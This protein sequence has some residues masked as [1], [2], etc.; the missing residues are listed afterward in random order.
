MTRFI[1][2]CA[3]TIA[4]L[5][6]ANVFTLDVQAGDSGLT[7]RPTNLT[8]VAPER[9][10]NRFGVT[11]ENAHDYTFGATFLKTHPNDN[12]VMYL[13]WYAGQI[14]R[15]EY[16]GSQLINRSLFLDI[17]DRT[18][19]F[20]DGT[21]YAGMGI[22][23]MEFDP[24]FANNNQVYIY[25]GSAPNSMAPPLEQR[26]S[27]FTLAPDGLTIDESSEEILLVS[28][29]TTSQHKA[30]DIGFG[31]DGYLY[32]TIGDD[33]VR[34][35]G[36]NVNT[37][38]GS[39]IRIDVNGGTPYAIPPDNP[40]AQGGGRPEIYA[41]GF[42]NPWRWNFDSLTGDLWLGDVG[43]NAWEEVNIVT[44]GGNYGWDTAEGFS[45]LQYEECD[46]TGLEPPLATFPNV[47]NAAVIGGY[48]YRGT[49]LPALQGAYIYSDGP[50]GIVYALIE[51]E[52]GEWEQEIVLSIEGFINSFEQDNDGEIWMLT[53]GPPGPAPNRILKLVPEQNTNTDFPETLT[54]TGCVDIND[55][56]SPA[57]GLIP[58]D[59]VSPLWSD[60]A[61]KSRYIAMPDW[62]TPGTTVD[63]MADGDFDFPI[64]TVLVKNFAL[65]QTMVET[66]L[67]IRHEDGDWGGYSYEWNAEQTEANLLPTGK[68]ATVEGQEWT[69]PSRAD[70]LQCHTQVA[71]RSLGLEVLQQNSDFHYPSTDITANQLDT[72]INIGLFSGAMS[73]SVDQDAMIDP[74]DTNE[75]IV[76]RARSYLHTNCSMCHRPGGPGRGP[77]DFRY[78]LASAD[79]GAINASPEVGSFGIPNALLL[80][81]GHPE[82]SIIS[83]RIGLRG[84][85]TGQMPPIG[86]NLVDNAG[87]AVVNDW[88]LSGLDMGVP[89]SDGDLFAD[90]VD[91]CSVVANNNQL[92]ADDDGYGNACDADLNNDCV[93]NFLDVSEFS[94]Q[95][96]SSGILTADFNGDGVVNFVDLPILSSFF[97]LGPG[98]SGEGGICPD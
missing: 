38:E 25:Y 86:T 17:R 32:L 33:E 81:P 85:T 60:G 80:A 7:V 20:F 35:N 64:G 31:A 48:V 26:L 77:E 83:Y 22:V 88:I 56:T 73:G 21:L 45:C 16:D 59:V 29:Q 55:P 92:D 96:L 8:C 61:I 43:S 24:D 58:Y 18:A 66:R 97:A 2:R 27:R 12:S 98:P 36:Q 30:G 82:Q 10:P 84:A 69:F 74:L 51:N 57:A 71:G 95:F 50:K 87:S 6:A 11:Y 76:D 67:F 15:F 89:D 37:L 1:V 34:A 75:Y 39:M 94:N 93:V 70:C 46:L 5:L 68:T 65:N 47:G 53:S 9:P 44:Q 3:G 63:V 79:I 78:Q 40:F 42:R 62:Q 91:N 72:L 41:W 49:A 52:I 14:F 23:D 13:T 4:A 54:E 28:P 19:V 90:N